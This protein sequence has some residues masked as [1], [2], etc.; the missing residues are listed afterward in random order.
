VVTAEENARFD[1]PRMRRMLDAVA[2]R[3]AL[4]LLHVHGRDIY[5]DQAAGLPVHAMNWHDRLT[6]PRLADAHRRFAGA[7]VGGL[8]ESRTLL[9]GPPEAVT[10]EVREA[11]TQTGGLGIIIGPGCV[12]PLATPDAHLAAVLAAVKSAA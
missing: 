5:F 9:K 6:E 8:G 7:L 12:L 1:L 4:T 2:G 10:A 11:L 3:S